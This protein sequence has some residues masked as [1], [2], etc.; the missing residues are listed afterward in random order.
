ME[1]YPRGLEL[2]VWSILLVGLA[3][4]L[5]L[6]C[7]GLLWEWA[8]QGATSGITP[9]SAT[10]LAGYLLFTGAESLDMGIGPAIM[11]YAGIGVLLLTPLARVL[12]SFIFFSVVDRN[13][14]FTAV[15]GFAL[16]VLTYVL[17]VR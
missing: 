13:W 8:F 11:V 5:A 3:V 4:A 9:I 7:A 10:N 15:T 14:K 17:F 16:V 1:K 2:L 6:I 12:A